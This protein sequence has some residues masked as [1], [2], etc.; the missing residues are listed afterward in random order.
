MGI[1]FFL[2]IIRTLVL[3]GDTQG[4]G[5]PP[6]NRGISPDNNKFACN[7]QHQEV[8][9]DITPEPAALVAKRIFILQT[10]NGNMYC[11]HTKNDF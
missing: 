2:F 11:S 10:L 3:R 7:Y 6:D 8:M 5:V 1:L 9:K 4:G